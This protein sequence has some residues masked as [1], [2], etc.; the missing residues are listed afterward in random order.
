MTCELSLTA[1]NNFT[2]QPDFYVRLFIIYLYLL[3][4]TNALAIHN[5][6]LNE[7]LISSFYVYN[8]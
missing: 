2:F 1:I 8:E 3:L 6:S 4:S 5:Q 7:A